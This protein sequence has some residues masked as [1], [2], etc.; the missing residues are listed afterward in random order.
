MG[1]VPTAEQAK[2]IYE[3][4]KVKESY[5]KIYAKC[6]GAGCNTPEVEIV[7]KTLSKPEGWVTIT[8]YP[9]PTVTVCPACFAKT[10]L[11]SV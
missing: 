9:G 2:Q 4:L 11:P 10:G 1:M 6:E 3:T 7:N 5:M 8:V